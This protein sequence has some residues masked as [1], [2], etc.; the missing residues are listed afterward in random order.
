MNLP[1]AE[2]AERATVRLIPTAYFRPPVLCGLVDTD[3]ELA[4][5][6][7]LEGLTNERLRAEA[8]GLEDLDRRELAFK[9]RARALGEWGTTHVNAAFSHTRPTGNR[10]NDARRGAWYCAF[11]ELT[12]IEE[13]AFHRTR[14][15]GFIGHFVDEM[16]YQG[17]LADF[18][19]TF[20]DIRGHPP[21]AGCLDPDPEVGYP[22]GQELARSLRAEGWSGLVYPSVRRRGGTC[23]VAFEPQIVQNVRPGAKWLLRWSG[24]PDYEVTANP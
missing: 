14:E 15:L 10:F 20:P 12:A 18:I 1:A 9:A 17:L 13:V 5:L 2:I 6:A 16:P 4:A 11:D 3:D 22:A 21:G 19:G 24:T 8:G 23:L 7:E